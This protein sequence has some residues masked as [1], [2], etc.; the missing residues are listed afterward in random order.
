MLTLF[1]P[2]FLDEADNVVGVD[3]FAAHCQYRSRNASQD[4]NR[5]APVLDPTPALDRTTPA[6][7]GG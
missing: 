7:T 1:P 2:E 5:C 6:T 3:F 4:V